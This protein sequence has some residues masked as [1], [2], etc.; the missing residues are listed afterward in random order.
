MQL[1]CARGPTGSRIRT[2]DDEPYWPAV[3]LKPPKDV[4]GPG[5]T[6]KITEPEALCTN[7]KV[8][9]TGTMVVKLLWFTFV[10]E[11]RDGT[12]W[13]RKYKIEKASLHS[14]TTVATRAQKYITKDT[15]K[16]DKR[17]QLWGL[18]L[19]AHDN[20]TRYGFL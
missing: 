15:F 9:P 10:D 17:K 12:R 3:V 6:W 13:Y 7:G 18:S 1:R 8:Q 16:F 11:D 4:Q 14:A 2:D 20:V 19:A 5:C